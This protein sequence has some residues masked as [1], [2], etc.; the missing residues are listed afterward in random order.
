MIFTDTITIYNHYK[1]EQGYDRW[2]R[3]VIAGVMWKRKIERSVTADGR[4]ETVEYISI[5]IPE[6]KNYQKPVDWVQDRAGWTLNTKNGLDIIALGVQTKDISSDYRLKDFK[7][8]TGDL[9]TVKAVHDNS[10]RDYL[11]H[12]KVIAV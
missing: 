9:G 12:I 3:T 2:K 10:N 5:S 4:L 7:R 8:D 6:P 1:D 11:K